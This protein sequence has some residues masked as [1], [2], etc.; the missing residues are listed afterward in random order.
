MLKIIC[1][2]IE[3]VWNI[4]YFI[5]LVIFAVF[6]IVWAFSIE[7]FIQ[8]RGIWNKIDWT[9]VFCFAFLIYFEAALFFYAKAQL[10]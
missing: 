6:W 9:I 3:L 10:N 2:I 5:G 1:A 7:L 4:I 8:L